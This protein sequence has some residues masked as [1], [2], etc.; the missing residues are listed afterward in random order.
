MQNREQHML[1]I[2]AC[3]ICNWNTW[4]IQTELS[5]GNL[6]L[7]ISGALVY[8]DGL[9]AAVAGPIAVSCPPQF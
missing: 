2:K 9:V 7:L 8:L 5:R 1:N 6:F 4:E 3:C